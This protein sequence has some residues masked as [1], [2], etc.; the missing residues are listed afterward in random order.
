MVTS[1][2]IPIFDV[3]SIVTTPMPSRSP[4][5]IVTVSVVVGSPV[6]LEVSEVETV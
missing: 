5:G 1:S 4:T 2:P 6:I 3:E